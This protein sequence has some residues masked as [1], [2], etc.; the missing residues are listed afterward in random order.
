[1]DEIQSAGLRVKLKRLDVDNKRR[2]K[3]ARYYWDNIKH[4][5]IILP[6]NNS[7]SLFTSPI[8]FSH[9]WHLF[10]IRTTNR[11][12]L[13]GYLTEKGIQ[14]LIHYPIPAHKQNAYPDWKDKKRRIT[15]DI[16]NQVLSLPIS[17]VITL[18]ESSQVVG[19]VN[20]W[21]T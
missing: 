15:E 7:F 11:Y 6:N 13:Q 8:S 19:A 5:E 17:Q 18:T 2:R 14:T 1:M 21:K 10:V 12:K 4:P 16:H 3:I 20:H 9:V